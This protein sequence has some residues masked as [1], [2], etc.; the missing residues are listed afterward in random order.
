MAGLEFEL[1]RVTFWP[2]KLS[3]GLGGKAVTP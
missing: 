1:F 2:Q 3:S